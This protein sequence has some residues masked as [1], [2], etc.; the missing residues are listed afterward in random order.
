MKGALFLV[1]GCVVYRMGSANLTDMRGLG[2]QM[3]FTMAAFV[4]AGLSLIGVPLTVGFISKWYLVLAAIER[5]WWPVAVLVL[6]A[7][8]LAV[9]YIWLVVEVAYFQKPAA[10]DVPAVEA[11]L[12]M[13]IPMWV[14]VGATLY[15]G[16]S[17]SF[18]SGVARR[19]AE[20]LVGVGP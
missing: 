20:L 9:I 3:P 6:L 11:P 17:S 2:R 13:L 18:T 5:G 16:V 8:L 19:G 10:E 1:M 14:L 12:S 4:L 7:S 15:F